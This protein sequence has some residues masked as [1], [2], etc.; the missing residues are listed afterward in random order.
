MNHAHRGRDGQSGRPFNV[1]KMLEL[2]HGA[3]RIELMDA[4]ASGPK[5][6]STLA[7]LLQ[8][9]V[10]SISYHLGKLWEGGAVVVEHDKQRRLYRIGRSVQVSVVGSVLTIRCIDK[11]GAQLILEVPIPRRG[12][13]LPNQ[14]AL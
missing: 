5:D 2:F 4:L 11:A 10:G 3:P 12:E 8:L 14:A 1:D 13:E 6:V 7:S 9:D